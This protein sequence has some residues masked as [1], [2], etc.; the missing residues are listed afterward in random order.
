MPCESMPLIRRAVALDA[1]A[2]LP[3]YRQLYRDLRASILTGALLPGTRLP[4]TR[5]LA[6]ALRVSRN[7]VVGAFEQLT[8][9]GYLEAHVGAG[10]FVSHA[11]PDELLTVRS[12]EAHVPNPP[13][14]AAP[15]LSQRGELIA[16]L[17]LT[18]L[19]DPE[20]PRPFRPGLPALDAFPVELWGRL[21][22]RCWRA[23][24]KAQLTYGEA[25]GYR[26]LRE[27]VA[28]YLRRARGVR[29]TAE[30]VLIVSGTQQ[31]IDLT[32][33]VLLGPG[34]A[35]WMEDPGYPRARGGFLAAGIR[36]VPVP[37]DGEGLN[38]EAGTARAPEARLAYVTPS[39][40]YPLGATMSLPRRL[41]LLD[42]AGRSGAWILEDDYDSEYRYAGRPIA[43]LQGLDRAGRVIYV[44][45]FSKVL[46]P[47]LRLGYLV[48]PRALAEAFVA[49]RAL[50]DRCPPLV[51]QMILTDFIREEH[52]ERH[53]R[54][55]RTLYAA[56]QAALVEAVEEHVG[57][58]LR[59]SS[60]PAGLHLVGRLPEGVDDRA[61]ARRLGEEGLVAP[62]LSFY[63]AR[64][65][66][67]GGLV[68]G[69][70]AFDEARIR[71]GVQR[72][73]TVLDAVAG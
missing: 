52:F 28:A 62:P 73:A 46:Y 61:V 42:W 57:G 41:A 26:P 59:I 8:D 9:E 14:A 69:Y 27:A 63:T 65:L 56:R 37:L 60:D 1:A 68:L 48:V 45:T 70:A 7:T 43:A 15:A 13:A 35:V 5:A 10:T 40:Q 2:A 49:A 47:A 67:R 22:A 29:A 33:R 58:R 54:R 19:R 17:D 6:G 72:L 66:D 71:R 23:M 24:P 12:A 21:A 55:M 30:H 34:D 44:G 3:L 20:R 50:A 25:A 11:L 32:A 4:S 38:L 53:I 18:R 51:S 39:H 64:P 16:R 31:A 36:P